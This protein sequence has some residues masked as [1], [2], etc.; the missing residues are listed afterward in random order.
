MFFCFSLA[1]QFLYEWMGL[2]HATQV[3]LGVIIIT[4]IV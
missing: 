1:I 2:V 3:Y 4:H